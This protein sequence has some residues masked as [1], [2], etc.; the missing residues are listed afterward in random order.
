MKITADNIG[1]V[2]RGLYTAFSTIFQNTA[3]KTV[4]QWEKIATLAPSD[5][6]ANDY[7]WMEALPKMRLWVGD[8]VVKRLKDIGYTIVNKDYEVTVAVKRNDLEDRKMNAY[9]I[10]IAG[11]S[12]EAKMHPDNLVFGVIN[13]GFNTPCLDGQ[14]FFDSDHARGD[15]NGGTVFWSN[16]GTKALSCASQAKADASFGAAWLSMRD[17]KDNEGRSLGV[18][19]TILL[20]PVALEIV[21]KSLMNNEKFGDNT[22]NIYKGYVEVVVCD[23]LT[24]PTAWFLLACND[25]IKPVIY[26][27]RKKAALVSATNPEAP[28]VFMQ[29]EYLYGVEAR[30]EA[31]A[32]LPH[33]AYGSTGTDNT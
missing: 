18:V 6:A 24:S 17:R 33:L 4:T 14:Y 5:S 13:S 29:A 26:Q 25:F 3:D 31:G 23:K 7:G 2:L 16:L 12:K 19:P 10:I 32:G 30:G 28:N 8:K 9:P 1:A 22:S 21:A 27:E 20:V 15:G 11:L